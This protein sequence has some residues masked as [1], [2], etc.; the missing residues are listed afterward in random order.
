MRGAD[1]PQRPRH[2]GGGAAPRFIDQ[3]TAPLKTFASA[4]TTEGL[5]ALGLPIVR[6]GVT[7]EVLE[8]RRPVRAAQ[9]HSL[10]D[11]YMGTSAYMEI[12]AVRRLAGDVDEIVK[13]LSEPGATVPIVPP[14]TSHPNNAP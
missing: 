5:A 3:V 9:V 8:G 6:E 1:L 2:R 12:D 11:E 14:S 7:I 4:A 10:I 13:R